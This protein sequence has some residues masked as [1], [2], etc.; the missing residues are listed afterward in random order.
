MTAFR[1]TLESC[2]SHALKYN[3]RSAWSAG[4]Q[5]SY[6]SAKRNG[7]FEECCKHMGGKV[8]HTLEN[9]LTVALKYQTAGALKKAQPN[10]YS[11]IHFN[12]WADECFA[13]M[14]QTRES[15]TLDKC[16][17]IAANYFVQ[18]HWKHGDKN[19]YAAA[20]R[21]G[22]LEQCCEHMEKFVNYTFEECAA[23]ASKYT[24]RTDWR[25]NDTALYRA[26]LRNK[27]AELCTTHMGE[28]NTVSSVEGKVFDY[29]RERCPDA[30]RGER[31]ILGAKRE[32]DIYIPSLKLGIEYNGLAW[33]SDRFGRGDNYHQEK[34]NV[35]K[36]KGVRLVH[37]WSDEWLRKEDVVKGYLDN[38]LQVKPKQVIHARQCDVIETTGAEQRDFLNK[39][40]LQ[41]FASGDGYALVYNGE[42]VAV[43]L[44]K[45]N[46]N[47]ELEVVRLC[48]KIGTEVSGGFRKLLA[49]LTEP[50]VSFCDTD[51]FDGEGYIRA[52]WVLISRAPAPVY[53][54]NKN[55]DTRFNRDTFK[56][57]DML[58]TLVA[59][60]AKDLT[61]KSEK[62]LAKMLGYYQ[63]TGCELL[64]FRL[65]NL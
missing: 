19:S 20:Y 15:W 51:K 53:Y 5:G 34:T 48:F 1:Y 2:K 42:V 29:V 3:S 13:H 24:T 14:V 55:C 7:W 36:S 40:H 35:A 21:N 45:R 17:T 52:G 54:V 18:N 49:R 32:I 39:N 64:K 61:G 65:E 22:W 12:H 33:H 27:W 11:A 8:Q 6:A 9:C 16:K 26:A 58:K 28:P 63:L 59:T 37:I 30:I 46:R 62:E 41:G 25:D 31:T 4:H 10:I 38:I 43:M 56:K 60:G 44:M 47:L 23:S 50:V 57:A